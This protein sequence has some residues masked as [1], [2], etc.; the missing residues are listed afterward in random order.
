VLFH[1]EFTPEEAAANNG[2]AILNLKITAVPI[3]VSRSIAAVARNPV[4]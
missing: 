4:P 2:L 3:L 1:I